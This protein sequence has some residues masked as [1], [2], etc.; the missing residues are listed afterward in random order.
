M[1]GRNASAIP[2]LIPLHMTE[3]ANVAA[4]GGTINV[5]KRTI[6]E[7]IKQAICYIDGGL[8]GEDM[9]DSLIQAKCELEHALISGVLHERKKNK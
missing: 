1:T 7:I 8:Q 6:R 9:L 4:H 3:S 2:Y 5:E